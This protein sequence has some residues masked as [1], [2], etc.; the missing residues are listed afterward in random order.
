MIVAISYHHGDKPL[1]ERWAAH[2]KK[3]G[4]YMNHEII[5]CPS[6][7]ATTENIE[8]PL[9]N[10]FR[11]VHVIPNNYPERGW[12]VSC[13]RSFQTIAWNAV[14]TRQ[15]FLFLEPDAIPL[16]EGWIDM[17]EAEYRQ[18][19][20]EFMGDFVEISNVMEGGVDHM[21]GIGV[22]H[23]DLTRVAPRVFNCVSVVKTAKGDVEQ[24][25]A[26]DI[27]AA[28]DILPKFHRTKL[29]QHDWTGTGDKPHQWRKYN[30][31]PS[32][33]KEGAVIYHP[34]KRGVL[35][36]DGLAGEATRV[37][38]ELR[39]G[40][41]ESVSS[42]E[43]ASPALITNEENPQIQ[44]QEAPQDQQAIVVERFNQI[45]RTAGS[46]SKL[47][48]AVKASLIN[49]GWI[50]AAKK[51]KRV[52]KK[53]SASVGRIKRPRVSAGASLPS[54]EEVAV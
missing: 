40:A 43:Q 3:L 13:N 7:G 36:N 45:L 54:C 49:H 22:Y 5:L 41:P 35:M 11:K 6:H 9:A 1:M 24:E 51:G 4:P 30:V 52:G 27:F 48:R 16:K 17:I 32:F 33:V 28:S 8:L 46:D 39:T 12:P 42:F 38:G 21:S 34:D 47:K 15:P 18:S 26:W 2:V 31:D 14:N 44:S 19:G 29:I 50:K 20:K 25:W 23:H 53:V 10:C 37:E